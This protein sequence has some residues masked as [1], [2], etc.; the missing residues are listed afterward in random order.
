M[1]RLHHTVASALTAVI[2][3]LVLPALG[4]AASPEPS[5]L[6][7]EPTVAELVGLVEHGTPSGDGGAPT[8][9]S[10]WSPSDVSL[11]YSF[12]ADG[13]ADSARS[14]T[15]AFDEALAPEG[16]DLRWSEGQSATQVHYLTLKLDWDLDGRIEDDAR[17]KTDATTAAA[18]RREA[19]REQAR[20]A[21]TLFV[22][23]RSLQGE[24]MAKLLAADQVWEKV[25]R[26]AAINAEL[27][28]LSSGGWSRLLRERA[29]PTSPAWLSGLDAD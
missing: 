1:S 15:D 19:H 12:R 2:A 6:A 3:S 23:R 16:V 25:A 11:T 27:D 18:K 8:A 24:L 5:P 21:I 10:R 14:R 28:L 22:E 17:S 7:W 20:R 26:I 4:N 9:A 13:D 29:P